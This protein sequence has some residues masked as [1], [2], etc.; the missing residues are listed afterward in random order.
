MVRSVAVA[1]VR[2]IERKAINVSALREATMF[3]ESLVLIVAIRA[4]TLQPTEV[5][6]LIVACMPLDVVSGSCS[7]SGAFPFTAFAPWLAYEL[8]ART[9]APR[10]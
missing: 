2:F 5:E 7:N 9:S 1:E 6:L 10:S 4:Q 8:G 3:R